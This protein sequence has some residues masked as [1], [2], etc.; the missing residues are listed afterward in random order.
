[1]NEYLGI[2]NLSI[3][4]HLH[5]FIPDNAIDILKEES[6]LQDYPVYAISDNCAI[7]VEDDNIELIGKDGYKIVK[8]EINHKC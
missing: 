3:V 8:G 5:S 7:V 6:K 2:V 4:P 1:M